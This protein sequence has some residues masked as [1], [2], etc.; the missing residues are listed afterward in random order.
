LLA[1]FL[2]ADSG[3]AVATEIDRLRLS[4]AQAAG[5]HRALDLALADTMY[6]LLLG[7][8]GCAAIGGRQETYALFA[9]TG[10]RLSGDGEL[11]AAAWEVFHGPGP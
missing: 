1:T 11:E 2:D 4:P 10:E 5:L 8:D 3:S 9:E 6:T 7:L